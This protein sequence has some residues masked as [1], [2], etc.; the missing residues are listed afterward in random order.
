MIR[1]IAIAYCITDS[2]YLSH[3]YCWLRHYSYPLVILNSTQVRNNGVF[4]AINADFSYT[5]THIYMLS[6]FSFL[7]YIFILRLCKWN[8]EFCKFFFPFFLIISTYLIKLH[9]LYCDIIVIS[10]WLFIVI[11]MLLLII[12]FFLCVNLIKVVDSKKINWKSCS[13]HP[14]QKNWQ[15]EKH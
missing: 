5:H 14:G 7:L 2:W 10:C 6:S 8:V 1:F 9:K 12:C 15:L 13:C 4:L 11:K 3:L